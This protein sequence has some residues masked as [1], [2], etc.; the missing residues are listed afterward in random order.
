[1]VWKLTRIDMTTAF[2]KSSYNNIF[3]KIYKFN[4]MFSRCERLLKLT[5]LVVDIGI[6]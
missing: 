2:I 5:L 3:I 6:E 4:H 1:M